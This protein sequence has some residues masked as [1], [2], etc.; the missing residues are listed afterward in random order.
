MKK[1]Y[2]LLVPA[3]FLLAQCSTNTQ[4]ITTKSFSIDLPKT[5]TNHHGE[6]QDSALLEYADEKKDIFALVEKK[7]ETSDRNNIDSARTD[8]ID[9]YILPDTIDGTYKLH[10]LKNG[11]MIEAQ[12]ADLMPDFNSTQTYWIVGIFPSDSANYYIVWTWTDRAMKP[13]NEKTL[14]KI[15]KSFKLK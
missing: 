4:K 10:R 1:L 11:Y 6:M 13:D 7:Q 5:M 15:V 14:K 12:T 2:I 3:L 8:F 9:Y